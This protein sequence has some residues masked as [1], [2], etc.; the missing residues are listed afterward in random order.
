MFHLSPAQDFDFARLLGEPSPQVKWHPPEGGLESPEILTMLRDLAA[1][2]RAACGHG[3]W[4][5]L[6]GN[7]LVGLIS[8]MTAPN[9][10]GEMEI[11]FGVAAS[12]R[13]HGYATQATIALA[14]HCRE[15]GLARTLTAESATFNIASQTTLARAGFV[16][17]H[18]R[19]HPDDGEVIGWRL[20][21]APSE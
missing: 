10:D 19:I 1:S 12:A 4:M 13:G 5:M 14:A 17:S 15:T 9:Q 8:L 21:L 11:G 20:S 16:Q 18:R 6:Q 7:Q 2:M 3:A